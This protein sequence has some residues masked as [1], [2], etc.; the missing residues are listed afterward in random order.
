[1]SSDG[2]GRPRIYAALIDSIRVE[3]GWVD[4][5]PQ[6]NRTAPSDYRRRYPHREFRIVPAFEGEKPFVLQAKVKETS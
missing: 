2:R 1:M 4:V 3:D 5:C 6:A